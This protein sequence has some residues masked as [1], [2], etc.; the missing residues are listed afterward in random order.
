MLLDAALRI[1]QVEPPPSAKSPVTRPEVLGRKPS[2]LGSGAPR[3]GPSSREPPRHALA[4][5]D[6]GRAGCGTSARTATCVQ[7][8][9]AVRIGESRRAEGF[10]ATMTD[11]TSRKADRGEAALPRQPRRAHRPA[12]NRRLFEGSA[13]VGD[14]QRAA[15]WP[16][17]ALLMVDLDRFKDVNDRFGHLAGD[18]LLV[19]SAAAWNCACAPPTRCAPGRRRVRGDPRRGRRPRGCRRGGRAHLRR[20]GRPS[21]R[22]RRAHR[23]LGWHRLGPQDDADA[24]NSS[25][26]RTPRSMPSST[27]AVAA[28]LPRQAGLNASIGTAAFAPS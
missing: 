14:R 9:S 3:P 2:M 21:R 25:A 12:C 26:A 24:G 7:W 6:A 4:P 13:A 8:M 17:F 27:A 5:P 28:S 15:P 10:V 20:H 23:R 11:I 18:A 1:V 16:R 19:R 22:G